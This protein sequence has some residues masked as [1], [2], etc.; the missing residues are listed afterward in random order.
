MMTLASDGLRRHGPRQRPR[1]VRGSGARGMP[2]RPPTGCGSYCEGRGRGSRPARTARPAPLRHRHPHTLDTRTGV[3]SWVNRGHHPPVVIRAGRWISRLECP[4]AP[5]GYRSGSAQHRVPRTVA[6]RRPHRPLHRRHHRSTGLRRHRVRSGTLHRPPH[7]PPRR[8]PAR[9]ETP[10]RLVK[11]VLDCHDGHLQADAT[12]L[13]CEWLSPAVDDTE[14][15]AALTGLQFSDPPPG[16][17][18]TTSDGNIG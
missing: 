14:P 7:P 16:S 6:A 9:P 2:Q 18:S 5:H 10:R 8:R 15:A 17:A 3:L 4:P 1:S 12:V 13:I 11:A